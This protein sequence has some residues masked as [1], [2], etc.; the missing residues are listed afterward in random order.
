MVEH[1]FPEHGL[2]EEPGLL[3]FIMFQ[4]PGQKSPSGLK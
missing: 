1:R 3:V 4:M 2:D